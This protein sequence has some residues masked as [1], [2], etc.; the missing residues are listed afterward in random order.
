MIDL[1]MSLRVL[2]KT[3][4][5]VSEHIDID[6]FDTILDEVRDFS[7]VCSPLKCNL[8]VLSSSA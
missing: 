6:S 8:V 5:K 7:R 4:E 1:D 2:R 3:H